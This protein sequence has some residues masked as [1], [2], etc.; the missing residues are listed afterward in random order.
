MKTNVEELPKN[1]NSIGIDLGIKSFAVTSDAEVIENPKFFK[2]A[3]K[4][5]L[6]KLKYL[7]RHLAKIKFKN[8]TRTT[9]RI[10]VAL[11]HEEISNKRNDFLHK[12]SSRLINENQVICLEDLNV[13]GM[14]KNHKLAQAILDVSWSKF[15][16]F[17]K[18]KADWYGRDLVFVNRF[19][20]SSKLCSSCGEKKTDL[21]LA[22]RE[23]ACS[24]CGITHDRD[25]NAALNIRKEGLRLLAA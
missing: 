8:R 9:R 5:A 17:L 25:F 16:G 3:S 7:Q 11:C 2:K 14:T 24:Y 12:L 1:S 21:T 23:W 15:V 4:K 18:Y 6:K 13:K 22:D 19:F 10:Q 20:P